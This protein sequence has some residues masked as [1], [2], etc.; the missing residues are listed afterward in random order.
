MRFLISG[1]SAAVTNLVVLFT[2][3]HFFYAWYLLASVISFV[4]AVSVSFIMQKF[5]TFNDYTREKI[6]RQ[7]ALYL[8]VQIFNLGVNT[9]LM[10]TS[11]DL[12]GIHYIVA[13]I[14]AGG[15]IAVYS[16]FIFKHF[17]F[18]STVTNME[19]NLSTPCPACGVQDNKFWANKSGYNLVKCG[20][21]DLIFV[22]PM[23][24]ETVA[25][26]GE[27]YFAS[28]EV[29]GYVDYDRDKEPM[30]DTFHIYLDHIERALG[31]KG[32]MLDVGAATG[33]FMDIAKTR[34][35]EVEG[36]EISEHAASIGRLKGL[37][38]HTGILENIAL[39][40]NSFDV[41]T[42]F[43]VL[44]HLREPRKT[45]LKAKNLLKNNGIIVVNTP[46]AG[47]FWA[48]IFQSR[49]HHVLPPEHLVLFSPQNF[50]QLLVTLEMAPVVS[51]KIGKR[52]TIPYI[53]QILSNWQGLSLWGKLARTTN[54]GILSKFK[55]P[56]N[57]RDN[58]FI[59]AKKI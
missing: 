13:Q 19:V 34:G 24:E 33:Y 37:R 57:L 40:A 38:I 12:L 59:I 58:F 23:P 44:E 17:I 29:H 48:K 10:Y 5:F 22:S 25:I 6:R 52:F 42:L 36:V 53:F 32:K 21:C 27:K 20:S 28:G 43:D 55:I 56:I 8:S 18:N 9:L 49:W 7:S 39:S 30:R 3:V 26:Y 14:F 41:I 35:W 31:R 51:L 11:V 47:S 16:F 4:C 46:D 54:R 45:L 1:G 50:S 2:L 15:I